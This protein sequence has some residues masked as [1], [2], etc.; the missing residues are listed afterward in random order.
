MKLIKKI[1]YGIFILLGVGLLFFY[2]FQEKFLFLP[3]KKLAKNVVFDFPHKF[4]E[5][6]IKAQDGEVLNALHFT[7]EKPAGLVLFFHGN[8]GNL[9]RWGTIVPY[10]LEY[11]YDVLVM[12][13]R[14]YGKS[15]GSFH[16]EN[17]YKDALAA[18]AYANTMYPEDKI[19]VYGRS[20]GSTFAAH[21]GTK[22]N[23]KHV[24]LEAPFYNMK[25]ATQFYFFL[26]PT[27]LLKYKF[28]TDRDV[29]KISVPLT[30]IHGDADE[31]TSFE[32]SKALFQLVAATKKEFVTIPTGTHHNLKDFALYKEKM[33]AILTRN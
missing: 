28:R 6:N 14:S 5:L 9:E 33:R 32:D 2:F 15:T 31:T 22:Y 17:M 24:V 4:K 1:V 23:P 21:V 3:G 18:Y 13:Y 10:L 12:D 26:S 30:I 20:L 25:K 19:V 8:K 11:G 16:E 27:F 7:I 29:Q